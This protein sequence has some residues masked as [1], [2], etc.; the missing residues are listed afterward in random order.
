[1]VSG[2]G[3]KKGRRTDAEDQRVLMT[4]MTHPMGEAR[5]DVG[6]LSHAVADISLSSPT[7]T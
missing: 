5:H 6:R 1:M 4:E 3:G 7:P 2:F